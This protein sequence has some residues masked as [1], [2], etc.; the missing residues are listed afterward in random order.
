MKQ[1]AKDGPC[2]LLGKTQED[3]R[4]KMKVV[5]NFPETTPNHIT[6][7]CYLCEEE[8]HLSRDCLKTQER[9]PTTIVE[10]EESEL[11]DLL[12]LERP[13]NKKENRKVMCF[14][15]K[16]LGHYAN[17]CPGRNNKANRQG[18]MK[19]NLNHIACYTCK[20]QGHYLYQC[21]EKSTSRL[22]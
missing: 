13:K 12:A 7:C 4:F 18:N 2:Q 22:Q 19:K 1:Q 5:D 21:T 15:C 20:Q 16:D 10:Y 17:Q 3:G 14:N 6:K 11:R 8:G 9:F